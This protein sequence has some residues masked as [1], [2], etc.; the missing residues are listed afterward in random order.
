MKST[1]TYIL[2]DKKASQIKV[3]HLL[4]AKKI[5]GSVMSHILLVCGMKNMFKTM[6]LWI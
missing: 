2:C 6:Q 3:M 5:K 1:N 4:C